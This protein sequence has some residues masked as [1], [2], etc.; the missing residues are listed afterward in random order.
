MPWYDRTVKF[1][2]SPRLTVVL[3]A[4]LM[5]LVFAGTWAQ[6][7]MGI[8]ATLKT[9]FRSLWVMIPIQIFLPRA[10][11]VPGVIP[12]PGG[13]LLGAMLFVNLIAAHV[14]RFRLTRNRIGLLMIH[15]ALLLLFVGEFVTALF[16]KE[17]NMTIDE[18]Q[19]VSYTEDTRTVELALVDTS[20]PR[21]DHDV[22]IPE[23]MLEHKGLISDPLLPV[24][25][26]VEAYFPNADL[27]TLKDGQDPPA[28]VP[29]VDRGAG[30]MFH[31]AAVRRPVANGVSREGIDLPVVYVTAFHQGQRL[32]TWMVPLYFSLV[33]DSGVQELQVGDHSYQLWL[34]YERTYKPYSIHLIDFAHDRYLGTD[35]PKNYSSRIR[36]VDPSQNEDREVLIY[37]N[38]PLR[39]HGETFYQASFKKGD[40]GTILQVVRNPG[41]LIPYIACSIGAIGLCLQFG[42]TLGRF[43]SR[44]R[45]T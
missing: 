13:A 34:R 16:A 22:V 6:I 7:D 21:V 40:S 19:T 38:N 28:S 27:V 1:W 41:W 24:E 30:A 10:W 15:F 26:Q 20:D 17:S 11:D 45:S 36:L 39:Y 37:M 35:T 3:L 31:L 8:W 12:Y 4:L 33:P 18:G 43:L 14:L 9:Y 29:A 32:G 23:R 2:S 5:F 42:A 25:L 44:R